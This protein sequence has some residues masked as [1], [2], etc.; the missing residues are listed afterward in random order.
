MRTLVWPIAEPPR[1]SFSRA[2]CPEDTVARMLTTL[3]RLLPALLFAFLLSPASARADGP[4]GFEE[5]VRLALTNNE[6]ARKAPLRVDAAEGQLDKAR[7]AFL[8]S[9]SA[10]A[11]GTLHPLDKNNRVLSGAGTL[12]LNQPLLNL[13]AIPLYAQARHTLE[14]ERWGAAQDKRLVAF[15]TAR[16]FLV[17]L[18]SQRLLE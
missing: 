12:Q 11:S 4:L 9:L 5:A 6:R 7:A 14:S 2:K 8:P 16:A 18:N 1:S 13:S 3:R 15:D 17:V 10:G